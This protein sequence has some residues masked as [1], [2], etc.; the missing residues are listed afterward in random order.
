MTFVGLEQRGPSGCTSNASLG[1]AKLLLGL[2]LYFGFLPSC[3]KQGEEMDMGIS[4]SWEVSN[5][6]WPL[7]GV[8]LGVLQLPAGSFFY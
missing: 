6:L 4:R 5:L 2:L 3:L 8:G 1:A 7:W